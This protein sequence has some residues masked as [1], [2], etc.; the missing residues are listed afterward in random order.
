MVIQRWQS[1]MLLIAAVMMGIFSFVS[2]GQIQLHDFSFNITSL[3]ILRE[4]IATSPGE[5]AGVHTYEAFAVSLL[6]A[7]MSL[8]AIFCYK[9]KKLHKNTVMISMLFTVVSVMLLVFDVYDFSS[10][11]GGDVQ[12]S[13]LICSPLIALIAEI[14]ALRMIRS[15]WK[16]LE[17][18]DR[19]R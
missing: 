5:P 4:G 12:W 8:I 19:L 10:E 18:A 2:L 15:D 9:S 14:I 17:A 16:K 3:G 1:V 6:A 7:V 13:V 11:C